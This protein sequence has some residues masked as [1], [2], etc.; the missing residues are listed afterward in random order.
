[1]TLSRTR[2]NRYLNEGVC[3]GREKRRYGVTGMLACRDGW[4]QLVGMRDE[5]WDAL[6]ASEEGA[7]FGERGLGPAASRA[8]R[9]DE[10]GR[11]LAEWCASRPKKRAASVLSTLGAPV[12]IFAD[13]LDCLG[14]EQLAH[15]AFFASVPDGFGADNDEVLAASSRAR[16]V[17]DERRREVFR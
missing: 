9:T 1:M 13:P 15:R 6:A 11:T 7:L 16:A 12:G 3:V 17:A 4:I 2:L 14:S 5:H 10:L 8:D